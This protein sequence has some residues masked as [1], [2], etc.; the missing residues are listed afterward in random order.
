MDLTN[1]ALL[2]THAVAA[3]VLT[4]A[5]IH[6]ALLAAR[7]RWFGAPL[8]ARLRRLYPKVAA[9]AFLLTFGLGLAL[10][11]PFRLDVR[12]AYLDLHHPWLVALFEVK[13]HWLAVTLL[14]LAY[15][16][17]TAHAL[18]AD[19]PCADDPLH[20][21]LTVAFGLVIACAALTGIILTAVKPV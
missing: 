10:Y 12:A 13:E 11:P 16:V 17:P 3:G 21:H 8:R 9:V 6:N 7:H 20:D 2:V 18:R 15:L 5:A 14:L 4:G 19:D 1:K